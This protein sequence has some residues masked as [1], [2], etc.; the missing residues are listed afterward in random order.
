MDSHESGCTGA[1]GEWCTVGS[2]AMPQ[3]MRCP[4][5]LTGYR[6]LG[7]SWHQ[8]A[9]SLWRRHNELINVWTH[10]LPVPYFGAQTLRV[11]L[12]DGGFDRR[13]DRLALAAFT[14]GATGLFAASAAF[15]LG[16]CKSESWF[17]RLQICDYEGINLLIT[18]MYIPG[19]WLSHGR[20]SPVAA[21]AYLAL[22]GAVWLHVHR[23]NWARKNRNDAG[24]ARVRTLLAVQGTWGIGVV[25]HFVLKHHVWRARAPG[26]APLPQV[27]QFLRS[28][29]GM[30]A[31]M[32]VGFVYFLTYFPECCCPG[33]FDIVGHSHQ[34]WHCCVTFGCH[35]WLR[36]MRRLNMINV[37]SRS[38]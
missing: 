36:E 11:L 26:A 17:R 33:R 2:D 4:H 23:S 32:G 16:C 7:L 8:I 5:I 15:H 34:W 29:G 22:T 27:V 14:A 31:S 6:P 3:V 25:L 37:A 1:N 20:R 24:R 19:V 21:R 38:K 28:V 10:L 35:W 30:W 9:R 18:S 12:L 13:S